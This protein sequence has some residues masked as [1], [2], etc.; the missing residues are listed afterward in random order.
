[1]TL[2][3]V[4]LKDGFVWNDIIQGFFYCDLVSSHVFKVFPNVV[5]DVVILQIYVIESSNNNIM[6]QVSFLLVIFYSL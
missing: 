3:L 5:G 1:V 6:F 2:L 4:S